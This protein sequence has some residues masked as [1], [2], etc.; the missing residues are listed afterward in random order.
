VEK[1]QHGKPQNQKN[2]RLPLREAIQELYSHH[3][4]EVVNFS[5]VHKPT[6]GA[7]IRAAITEL[8]GQVN[9]AAKMFKKGA[10]LRDADVAL[11]NLRDIVWAAYDVRCISEGQFG[12][13]A[14]KMDEVG[15]MLGGWINSERIRDQKI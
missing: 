15:R 6:L 9:R 14:E 1:E 12:V 5:K 3:L 11:E 7:D 2:Q 13:W 4:R 8:R 10:A